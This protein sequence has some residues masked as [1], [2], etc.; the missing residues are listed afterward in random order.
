MA[1]RMRDR[2]DAIVYELYNTVLYPYSMPYSRLPGR[3]PG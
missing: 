2:M 1:H 3:L